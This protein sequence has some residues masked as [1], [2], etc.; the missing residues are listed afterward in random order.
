MLM[1]VINLFND[2]NNIIINKECHL[3]NPAYWQVF[4]PPTL[5]SYQSVTSS[6]TFNVVTN[7]DDDDNRREK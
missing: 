2:I 6:D 7:N 5:V 3:L 4:D 1:I